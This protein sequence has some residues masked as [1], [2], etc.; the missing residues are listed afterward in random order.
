MGAE[1]S[2]DAVFAFIKEGFIRFDPEE[3]TAD[4]FHDNPASRHACTKKI[5]FEFKDKELE[6]SADRLK[7]EVSECRLD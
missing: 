3:M 1:K 4:Q 2:D 7:E 6:R 5:G